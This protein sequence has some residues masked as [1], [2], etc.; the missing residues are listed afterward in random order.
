MYS[1]YIKLALHIN[2]VIGILF[3][4]VLF[5]CQET[6]AIVNE[7]LHASL[8]TIP[9]EFDYHNAFFVRDALTL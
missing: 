8:Y 1:L 6:D 4:F 9:F 5:F 7:K 3:Y 2:H